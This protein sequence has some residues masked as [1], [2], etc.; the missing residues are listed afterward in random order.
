MDQ[1]NGIWVPNCQYYHDSR[2]KIKLQILSWRFL[3]QVN[4]QCYMPLKFVIRLKVYAQIMNFTRQSIQNFIMT[5]PLGNSCTFTFFWQTSVL[6]CDICSHRFQENNNT[7]QA[8]LLWTNQQ[9]IQRKKSYIKSQLFLLLLIAN[10]L[11][12]L[13]CFTR[14][15]FSTQN[16]TYNTE[17][18]LL[19]V[20]YKLF[21]IFVIYLQVLHCHYFAL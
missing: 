1:K 8:S 11:K 12:K 7:F 20:G 16:F 6:Q 13:Q 21:I 10:V 9:L 14:K 17:D 2:R 3:P 5:P 19:I 15:C 18:T 4:A